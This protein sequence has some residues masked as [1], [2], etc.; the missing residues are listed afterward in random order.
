[1]QL[2]VHIFTHKDVPGHYE[3]GWMTDVFF[4]GGTL[5]SDSLLLYFPKVCETITVRNYECAWYCP[6]T[7]IA[8]WLNRSA[9]E[10][11]A[12]VTSTWLMQ[13]RTICFPPYLSLFLLP[14]LSFSPS[15]S[16]SQHM[17]IEQH[18]LVNGTHYQ[19]TLGRSH[20]FSLSCPFNEATRERADW[21]IRSEQSRA[22]Q[23]REYPWQGYPLSPY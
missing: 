6:V 20:L 13:Y 17:A 11:I 16:T 7:I 10:R 12:L 1:M 21:A 3:K 9:A 15:L 5:P 14:S 4:S 18:W 23:S 19:K 2:F 8:W 22:E